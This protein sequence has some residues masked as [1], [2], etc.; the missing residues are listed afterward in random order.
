MSAA[1]YQASEA[2]ILVHEG[3]YTDGVHPYDPGGCT[4]FGVTIFDAKKFWKADATCADVRNMP[5][6]VALGIIKKQ[7]W[8][9]L[10][11]DNLPAGVDDAIVDYG[12]NSGNS[13]AGKVLRRLLNLSDSG[14]VVT[15]LVIQ[16]AKKRDPVTLI[17]AIC[18]ERMRFLEGLAIWPTYRGGWTR[19][20]KEVRQFATQL[21]GNAATPVSV[22]VPAT[23]ETPAG[24]G[25]GSVSKPNPGDV[26]KNGGG[27]TGASA[28]LAYWFGAHPAVTALVILMGVIAIAVTISMLKS[29]FQAKQDAPTPGVVP[30]PV[31]QEA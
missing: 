9:A 23:P 14:W 6:D 1:D 30:V 22:P 8:D 12:Y 2:R 28:G 25:K 19:R 17:N 21:A 29:R 16:E 4:N 10:N 11:C 26:I 5:K 27:V 7:Y 18:D 24:N 31:K 13:R 3:G 15:P 20:V